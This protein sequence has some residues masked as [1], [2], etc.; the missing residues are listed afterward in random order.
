MANRKPDHTLNIK[1]V[2]DGTN[3]K[4]VYLPV[5]RISL[6]I[7]KASR[8][9]SGTVDLFISPDTEYRCYMDDGQGKTSTTDPPEQ[10][11][12]VGDVPF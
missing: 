6:W 2:R 12:P 8:N 4:K 11:M 9:I 7:D 1:A 10:T 5:G 3:G